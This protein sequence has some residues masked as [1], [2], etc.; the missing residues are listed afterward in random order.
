MDDNLT[1]I[2]V[3]VPSLKMLS[4]GRW[5][6]QEQ[7]GDEIGSLV[8]DCPAL[9]IL[10]I[11][12]DWG[13]YCSLMENMICLHEVHVSYVPNPDEK[14]LR[15]LSSARR[16]SLYLSESM[17]AF[18]NANINF[19]RLIEFVSVSENPVYWVEPLVF[20]LQNSPKP[21]SRVPPH[22]RGTSRILFHNAYRLI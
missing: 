11:Y 17:V 15:C 1:N 16:L 12:D 9:R 7:E 2:T 21:T 5:R 6:E 18:C 20:L 10:S 8:I 3:K 13:Y 4:Y 22:L 14:F 19:S